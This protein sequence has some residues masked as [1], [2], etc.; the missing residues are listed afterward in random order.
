[1]TATKILVEVK[2]EVE[3]LRQSSGARAAAGSGDVWQRSW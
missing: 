2:K 3:L 1:V